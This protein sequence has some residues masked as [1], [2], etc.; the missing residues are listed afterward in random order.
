MEN[1]G[2]PEFELRPGQ[3]GLRESRGALAKAN[4]CRGGRGL[5]DQRVDIPIDFRL[6]VPVRVFVFVELLTLGNYVEQFSVPAMAALVGGEAVEQSLMRGFLQIHIERG[7]NTESAFEYLV[8]AILG[9][10]IAADLF[11]VVRRER[12]LIL[13]EVESY[14]LAFCFGG[15][16]GGDFAVF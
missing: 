8:A 10:E 16:G 11:D 6:L 9:F 3:I 7:V 14:G 15:L 5:H 13:L 1:L 2:E 12:V 4:L